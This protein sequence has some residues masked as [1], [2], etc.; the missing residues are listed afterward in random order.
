MENVDPVGIHTGD[1]VVVF[2]MSSIIK[3][4]DTKYN[5]D[6]I[7]VE[8]QQQYLKVK[9]AYEEAKDFNKRVYRFLTA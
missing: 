1:S 7:E 3:K 6:D 9:A 2:S 8:K 4:L 5:K